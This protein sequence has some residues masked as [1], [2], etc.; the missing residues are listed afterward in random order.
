MGHVSRLIG[1]SLRHKGL[2]FGFLAAAGIG[3][4]FNLMAPLVLIHII[5]DVILADNLD[6]LLPNVLLYVSLGALYAL[7]DIIGRLREFS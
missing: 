6:Q 2:L 3:T 7:F 1:Y 5:D 4:I